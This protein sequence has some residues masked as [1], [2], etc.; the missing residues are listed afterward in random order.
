MDGVIIDSEQ[1]VIDC[2]KIVA[3]KYGIPDIESFCTSVLG[4]NAE[5]TRKIF[6]SKY[7]GKF[8]YD[9]FKPEMRELFAQRFDAGQVP[10]KPGA[11]E[12]LSYLKENGIKTALCSSTSEAAVKREM[13][14]V[15]LYDY[16]DA[17]MCGD[18]VTR[19]KPDPEIWI[20]G[21]Q[22]IGVEA[23]DAA[24]IEDSYNG[25]RSAKAAGLYTFMVPDLI[26][27]DEEMRSLAD[28]ILPSLN[29]VLN[30]V[31]N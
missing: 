23:S 8:S 9:D 25:V 24:A 11:R 22:K 4:V 7:E 21:L 1:A 30:K 12:L 3:D 17:Y 10:V 13:R 14:G 31:C 6:N 15:G 27:P 2:W 29:E 20:K 26:A 19:S 5:N 28:E 16:F 18:Q